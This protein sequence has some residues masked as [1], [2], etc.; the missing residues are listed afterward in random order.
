MHIH[1]FLRKLHL[2][3]PS[4]RSLDQYKDN[5]VVRQL[6]KTA[7]SLATPVEKHLAVHFTKGCFCQVVDRKVVGLMPKYYLL[8]DD[9]HMTS[10]K[11]VQF[12]RPPTPLVHLRP[13]F[14]HPVDLGRPISNEPSPPL[15]QND[16]HQL[17]DDIIQG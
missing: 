10:M 17:K 16:N 14:F 1:T 12:S 6:T 9:T 13:K 8:W 3:F 11:V 4:C 15:S 2:F 7:D 5:G